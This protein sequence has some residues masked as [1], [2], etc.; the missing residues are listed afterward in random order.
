MHIEDVDLVGELIRKRNRL[1]EDRPTYDEGI[2]VRSLNDSFSTFGARFE[3]GS[4][5]YDLLKQ[6]LDAKY[7]EAL[8]KNQVA[9]EGLGV[10]FDG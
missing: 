6:L 9:L 1:L 4:K 5:D 7:E 2:V 8:L 10:T 3:E